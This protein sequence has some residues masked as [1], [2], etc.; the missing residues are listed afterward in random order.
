MVNMRHFLVRNEVEI[1]M[2][3]TSNPIT[4]LIFCCVRYQ[5]KKCW[6]NF[7][8]SDWSSQIKKEKLQNVSMWETINNGQQLQIFLLNHK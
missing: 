7:Q 2:E 1:R 3:M 8:N 6:L 5:K 4:V